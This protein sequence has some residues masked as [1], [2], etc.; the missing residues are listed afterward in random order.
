M[1]V[2]IAN[3]HRLVETQEGMSC[4]LCEETR[5]DTYAFGFFKCDKKPVSRPQ[6]I[7]DQAEQIEKLDAQL[8]ATVEHLA[9]LQ[10]E[11]AS[12]ADIASHQ[13]RIMTVTTATPAIKFDGEKTRYDLFSPKT[14]ELVGDVFTFGAKKYADRNW[15]K[16]MAWSRMF[17]AAMRHLWAFWR[18]DRLDPESQLPHLAH[19]AWC[20]LAL[21]H[22]DECGTQYNKHDDRSGPNAE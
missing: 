7:A 21:L 16:G 14:L 18:G 13:G 9:K 15:E 20:V 12:L 22:Y 3:E 1:T 11:V 4:L 19:A 2:E 8:G 6:L 5:V 17:N 10:P